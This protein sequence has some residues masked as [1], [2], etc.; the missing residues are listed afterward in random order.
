MKKTMFFI[1]AATTMLLCS[2]KPAGSG[3]VVNS[4]KKLVIVG[5]ESFLIS[6]TVGLGAREFILSVERVG[7]EAGEGNVE[8]DVDIFVDGN[9]YYP[10]THHVSMYD[11]Q[12]TLYQARQASATVGTDV[13]PVTDAYNIYYY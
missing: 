8:F 9:P 2:F 11:G 13:Y 12:L 5:D 3:T 6:T 1:L 7:N 10:E 4:S